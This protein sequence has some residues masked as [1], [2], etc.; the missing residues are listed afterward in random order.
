MFKNCLLSIEEVILLDIRVYQR[1]TI[2]STS[3]QLL[4]GCLSNP[5]IIRCL[6]RLLY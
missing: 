2:S 5:Y 6:C 4:V 1:E 3:K